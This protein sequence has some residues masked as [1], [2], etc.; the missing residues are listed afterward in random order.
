[1]IVQIV[2]QDN[3]GQ[4]EAERMGMEWQPQFGT[5]D[6]HFKLSQLES[7][8]IDHSSGNDE[9]VF[10]LKS[11]GEYRTPYYRATDEAFTNEIKRNT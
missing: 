1:M 2:Y 6:F 9:I 5:T 4:E 7:F 10:S 11:G 8:W 3:S